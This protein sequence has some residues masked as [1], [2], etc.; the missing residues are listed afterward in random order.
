MEFPSHGTKE[1]IA[2]P[3]LRWLDLTALLYDRTSA[4]C[5][6]VAEAL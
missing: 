2:M 4:R 1:G 3:E 6:A 5:M